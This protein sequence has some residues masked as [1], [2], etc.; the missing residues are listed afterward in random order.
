VRPLGVLREPPALTV[1]E[2]RC[3]RDDGAVVLD[4]SL[5][6]AFGGA[7][8]P[9]ALNVGA[10]ASFATWAGTVLPADARVLLVLDHPD[11][12]WPVTWNLL[13]IGYDT[14]IGWLAGGMTAW[15]TAAEPLE[16]L[17]QI[18]VHELRDRL[19]SVRSTC[20]TS[21]SPPNRRPGTPPAPGSSPAPRYRSD[22]TTSPP[23]SPSL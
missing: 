15:R 12:L 19:R 9:G 22:S 13:R 21:A 4:T 10:G 8:L 14:P 23:T 16:P 20:S 7:H 11:E 6:E 3:A 17:P 1:E 5:P 18:T 2:F